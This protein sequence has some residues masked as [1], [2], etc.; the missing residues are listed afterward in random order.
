M[1]IILDE[2]FPSFRVFAFIIFCIEIAINN[3]VDPVQTPHSV[4]SELG[5]HCL[6]MSP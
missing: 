2:F 3:S 6:H 1:L 4:G 5:L